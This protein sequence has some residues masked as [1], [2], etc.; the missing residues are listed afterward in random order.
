MIIWRAVL[1]AAC[2]A[3]TVA[4]FM[5]F[6][7][8]LSTFKPWEFVYR[9]SASICT[10]AI[11]A[12]R[13][14]SCACALASTAGVAL[15]ATPLSQINFLPDLMHVYFLFETVL[16]VPALVQEE[17]ARPAPNVG[18]AVRNR[19]VTAKMTVSERALRCIA[20]GYLSQ[21]SKVH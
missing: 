8:G 3:A 4:P 2:C 20:R 18:V 9:R 1:A 21:F 5:V 19:E 7:V 10:D 17:P 14:P 16:V 6:A 15:T 12:M 13:A 11:F